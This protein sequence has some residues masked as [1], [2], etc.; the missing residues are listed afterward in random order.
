[1]TCQSI[2]SEADVEFNG[3]VA[4]ALEVWME[5]NCKD[6]LVSNKEFNFAAMPAAAIHTALAVHSALGMYP[7]TSQTFAPVLEGSKKILRQASCAADEILKTGT[8]QE[9][10]QLLASVQKFTE[11]I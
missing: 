1:M 10:D 7:K 9:K 6:I 3:R 4:A 2:L 8:F 5:T 11:Q